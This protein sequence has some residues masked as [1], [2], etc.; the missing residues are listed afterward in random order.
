VEAVSYRSYFN[1]NRTIQFLHPRPAEISDLREVF[2]ERGFMTNVAVSLAELSRMVVFKLAD[3]VIAH[4]EVG[5]ISEQLEMIRSIAIGT[6]V[7]MLTDRAP[8]I[9]EVVKSVRAGAFAVFAR[10]LQVTEVV[11]EI[12]GELAGDL[13]VR[14]EGPIE[15][16][17]MTS[18]TKR[19]REVLSLILA[20][21]SNKECGRDLGISPRTIEVHRARV[22]E[23]LGARNAV[24]M[25]RIALGR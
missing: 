4:A 16:A 3:A 6:K 7:F 14:G 1:R 20:G 8:P 18:L 10:P 15:V 25:V 13:R 22:M 21:G 23:K 17:G 24:E 19:E 5:Y 9:A 12:E 2:H 11:R